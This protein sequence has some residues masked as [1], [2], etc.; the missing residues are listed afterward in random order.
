ML[1]VGV[2]RMEREVWRAAA[3]KL[4]RRTARVI[5][6]ENANSNS[7]R[8]GTAESGRI[9]ITT[10]MF[11]L[12]GPIFGP[13]GPNI[14]TVRVSIGAITATVYLVDVHLN[15]PSSRSSPRI[16]ALASR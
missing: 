11:G 8:P 12:V 7:N 15:R 3:A 16:A 2:P 9:T 13:T 1:G 10:E 4:Q 14:F 5:C 6:S